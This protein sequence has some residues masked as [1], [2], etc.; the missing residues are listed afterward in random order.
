M[1]IEVPVEKNEQYE[2]TIDDLTY[3][4][5]GVA[6]IDD[7]PIFIEN[8]LPTE[9]ALIQVIKVKKSFA[10]GRLIK[11]IT[12]SKDRVELVNK[13]Y[14]QTGIAPLQHLAYESQLKFKQ[15]QIEVDF[16]KAKY[17]VEVDPTIGM[18]KP[19]QYRNKAQ[20]PVRNVDGQLETGFYRR[21]SHDLVPIEDFY[22]QDPKIDEAIIIVRDIL[23]KFEVPAYDEIKHTG[24]IR[25]VMVRRGHYSGEMM[26]VLIT[27]TK[28]L[29]S[30]DQIVEEIRKQLPEINSIVQNINEKKTNALMGRK[31]VVLFGSEKIIDK[32]MGL[33]FEISPTSFY[34]VNPV[35]TEKLYSL[36][37]EKAKLNK[38]DVV[39]DAYCG[40]GTISLAVAKKVKQVYGVEVVEDA[41]RDAKRNAKLNGLDNVRF[42]A[43]RAETQMAEWQKQGI[44]P[45]VVIV[46][47][48]RKGLD[49]SL[50]DSIDEMNP[51]RVVYVSCNP[52]TLTRDVKLFADKG[53]K[54]NQPI[55]PVD[56][57]PQTTHIESISVLERV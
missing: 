8:T 46:D 48:P 6:K 23:R 27:R 53:Y 2:V 24:V 12:K 10:Y 36:A 7:F 52:A 5:M 33:M 57:F 4:G 30:G 40:I 26:I 51:E 16:Q 18:E 35:Q 11:L 22:I 20:I 3:E 55:Q 19:Y 45:D 38:D 43:N 29:P 14:T 34:Q 25:N 15:H 42:V 31:N 56:Q 1:K 13:T 28:K 39:I 9:K 54:L 32:L 21:H 44:K 41:V 37:I 49:A 50:I 17:P 47:P